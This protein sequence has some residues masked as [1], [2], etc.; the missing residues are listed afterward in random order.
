MRF[1]FTIVLNGLHHLREG[2]QADR[3]IENVDHWF[4]VEGPAGSNGS[5]GWCK[6][7][8]QQFADPWYADSK[9]WTLNFLVHFGDKHPDKVTYA[10]RHREFWHSKDAMVNKAVEMIKTKYNLSTM[11]DVFLWEIDMDEYWTKEQMD[12]AE[13]ELVEKGGDCGCFHADH[14]IG[15]HLLAKGA[16][17]EGND[18]EDPLRNSYRRL[19]RWNGKPFAT[20]EPPVLEGGNGKEVL[21]TPRMNHKSYV[22]DKDVT[23]KMCWYG[24][25]DDLLWRWYSLVERPKEDFP[26]PLS[27]LITG[28]WG[29]SKT[30]IVWAG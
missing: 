8:P 7:I 30:E 12:A 13:K 4:V 16:W 11:D 26:R 23:F 15:D 5:T 18:P 3:I 28:P 25:H 24:G 6:Q 17:G 10:Y 27:D 19:W 1:A 21:L 9:D 29:K 22:Y 2:G 20:H 14:W